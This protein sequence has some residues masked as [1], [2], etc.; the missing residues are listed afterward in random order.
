M[1]DAL[2]ILLL[3]SSSL[4]AVLLAVVFTIWFMREKSLAMKSITTAPREAF[5]W[6]AI[7]FTFALGTALGDYLAETIGLGYGFSALA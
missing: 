1:T 2:G 6:L 5:Y 7:L 3:I 4:F